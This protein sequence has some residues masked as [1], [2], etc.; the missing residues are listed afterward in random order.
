MKTQNETP[1]AFLARQF[2][3][4]YEEAERTGEQ[5]EEIA[6]LDVLATVARQVVADEER[7]AAADLL[8]PA[9]RRPAD[10]ATAIE[11]GRM[12]QMA[13]VSTGVPTP[14]VADVCEYVTGAVHAF[15]AEYRTTEWGDDLDWCEETEK[16]L[17]RYTA[18]NRPPWRDDVEDARREREAEALRAALRHLGYNV[19]G[20]DGLVE[21]RDTQTGKTAIAMECNGDGTCNVENYAEGSADSSVPIATMLT[22]ARMMKVCS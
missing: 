19:T 3:A 15:E 8:A 2:L 10:A 5:I 21:I 20:L 7:R 1:A 11:F 22:Y 14:T 4:A 18:A 16:F 6:R 9:W 13:I 12:V 17:V